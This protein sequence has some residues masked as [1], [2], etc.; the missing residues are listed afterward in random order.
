MIYNTYAFAIGRKEDN[1]EITETLQQENAISTEASTDATKED[2]VQAKASDGGIGN[3]AG[4]EKSAS[5]GGTKAD[6]GAKVSTGDKS[7]TDEESKDQSPSPFITVAY[8]HKQHEFSH[9]QAAELVQKALQY[10]QLL[11]PIKR[12]AALK[13]QKVKEFIAGFERQMEEDHRKELCG[14][15]GEDSDTIEELMELY[16]QKNNKVV[17]DAEA[18]EELEKS[19]QRESLEARLAEEFIEL[20]KEF[21]EVESFDALPRSVKAAAANGMDLLSAFLRY[22]HI[23]EKKRSAAEAKAAEAAAAASGSLSSEDGDRGEF[24]ALMRGL[25]GNS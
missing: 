16:R 22:R 8:N 12:A 25:Y 9:D 14:R 1:M 4:E 10:D 5:D 2:T 7:E 23:E 24:D 21:P 3:E 15:Y 13:G 11:G 17:E 6:E 19:K 18:A 20:G